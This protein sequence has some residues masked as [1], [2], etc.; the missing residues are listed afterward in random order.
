MDAM[1][2]TMVGLQTEQLMVG[3]HRQFVHKY[4][5]HPALARIGPT[6]RLD[7][8]L[9]GRYF[10][11]QSQRI[12]G[13]QPKTNARTP[14]TPTDGPTISERCPYFGTTSRKALGDAHLPKGNLARSAKTATAP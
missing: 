11:S 4:G 5:K 13:S 10:P 3:A 7:L 8:E 6:G 14:A 1:S 2:F 12:L 9:F